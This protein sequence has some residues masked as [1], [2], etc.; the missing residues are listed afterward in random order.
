MSGSDFSAGIVQFRS[1]G[2]HYSY[3][4]E[5]GRQADSVDWHYASLS[6]GGRPARELDRAGGF[7][8]TSGQYVCVGRLR[9]SPGRLMALIQRLFGRSGF[10]QIEV[11]HADRTT[12][13]ASVGN[14][15]GCIVFAPVV[16]TVSPT[17]EVVVRYLDENSK[18]LGTDRTWVGDG[19]PPPAELLAQI[20][21]S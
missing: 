6:G 15:G 8:I 13:K 9:N 10:G 3:F 12:Y 18:T 20:G 7:M 11:E 4:L 16:E 17:D 19:S 5:A 21:G 1:N 2:R 14:D